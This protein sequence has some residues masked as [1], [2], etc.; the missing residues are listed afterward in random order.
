MWSLWRQAALDSP[1]SVTGLPFDRMWADDPAWY[2]L[3]LGGE[4]LFMGAFQFRNVTELVG[5]EVGAV[6]ALPPLPR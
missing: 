3:M 6:E 4:G 2:P 1:P 5:G